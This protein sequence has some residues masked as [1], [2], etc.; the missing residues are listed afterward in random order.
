MPFRCLPCRSNVTSPSILPDPEILIDSYFRFFHNQPYSFFDEQ[1]FRQQFGA[2]KLPPALQYAVYAIAY[3]F[4]HNSVIDR[5]PAQGQSYA[6]MGWAAAM[7]ECFNSEKGPDLVGVQAL[8]LLAI[9][10]FT[11]NSPNLRSVARSNSSRMQTPS[12]LDKNRPGWDDGT[13]TSHDV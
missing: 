12:G 3:R 13:S 4:V 9:F 2:G 7:T 8:T 6:D 1:H 11:G 5:N 10:D